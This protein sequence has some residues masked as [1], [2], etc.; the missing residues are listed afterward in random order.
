MDTQA[1]RADATPGA[2]APLG[3]PTFRAL[4]LAILVG[5][6]GTWVND[7]AA[8]W[9]MTELTD[10]PLMIAAVQ[11]A[12]SLPMVVLALT[13]GTLADLVDRRRLL[14]VMQVWMMMVA[15]AL[16]LLAWSQQL[17]AWS[18]LALTFALGAGAALAMPAQAATTQEL[19][20]RPLVAPAI[21]LSSV[22]MNI[23]RSIGPALGGTIVAAAGVA[24]AFAINALSF[25]GVVFVLLRW[26]RTPAAAG[27]RAP[28]ESFIGAFRAGLRFA[29]HAPSFRSVIVRAACFFVFA[30]ALT[31]LLPLVVRRTLQGGAGTF[32]LLLGCIGVGALIGAALLPRVRARIGGDRLIVG[33][34]V[35][36]A[37]CIALTAHA[38]VVWAA[39]AVMLVA[40]MTWIAVLSSFQAAAQLSVPAWVRARALS[41]YIMT[42]A[43]GMAI[44]S[45]AWGSVAQFA[46]VPLALRIAAVG[47][48]VASLW[49]GRYRIGDVAHLDLAPSGHWPQPIVAASLE[50]DRGPVLVTIEYALA[51]G[52]RARFHELMAALGE[53]RRRDGA[54]QWSVLE[55]V[56]RPDT[57]LESFVLGSWS[58]H[59]RQHQRVT[60]E[61]RRLQ[62]AIAQTLAADSKPVIRHFLG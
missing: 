8:A 32:G 40:G 6:I 57:W 14:I 19:V 29:W 1:P 41:L 47:T 55:D 51:P 2:W 46:S 28:P 44:G 9:L 17:H 30:S 43:G 56:A 36:Y 31:A 61:E 24:A 22:G 16:A 20:P 15:A 5:N 10:A 27:G 48:I 12:T 23:A 62:E 42:F 11:S 25:L 4:W 53:S 3:V 54:L 60:G 21:A 13:A 7:V 59:L 38:T 39:C 26:K 50:G 34:A 35:G 37:V 45:L 18:L 49:A 52:Q 33:G 58:E